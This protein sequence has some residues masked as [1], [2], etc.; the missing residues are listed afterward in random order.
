MILTYEMIRCGCDKV[1]KGLAHRVKPLAKHDSAWYLY[2]I[3]ITLRG[4]LYLLWRGVAARGEA[5][6][7]GGCR[8]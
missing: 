4:E 5:S 8:G 6:T 3:F 7:E 2:E 1:G